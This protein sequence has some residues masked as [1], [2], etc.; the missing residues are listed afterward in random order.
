MFS[1]NSSLMEH[2]LQ[3]KRLVFEFSIVADATPADKKVSS[4]VPGAVYVRTQGL[5][6][7]ADA[8]EDLTG[9]VTAP[10]DATGIFAVLIALPEEKEKVQKIYK[11]TLTEKTATGSVNVVTNIVTT[12]QNIA[13]N[14]DSDKSLATNSLTFLLEVEYLTVD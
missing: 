1:K 12:E 2:E 7:E 10:N 6:D 3:T 8:V 5:T 14:I 4:D 9:Q 11:S 13:I